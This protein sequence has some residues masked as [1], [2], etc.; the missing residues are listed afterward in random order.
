MKTIVSVAAVLTSVIASLMSVAVLA[1][2]NDGRQKV[3]QITS[4]STYDNEPAAIK[5]NY[6]QISEK[7]LNTHYG[8]QV[9]RLSNRTTIILP[10]KNN[11]G[12]G[13]TY[14][15]TTSGDCIVVI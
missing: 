10:P 5:D 3:I 6:L 14:D 11:Q 1:D 4:R 9:T 8:V 2:E 13:G 7:C 15:V 12:F